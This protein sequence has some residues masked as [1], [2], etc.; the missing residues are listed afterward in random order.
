MS[1]LN[2]IVTKSLAVIVGVI[3]IYFLIN[4]TAKKIRNNERK[5]DFRQQ[6]Y[7]DGVEATITESKA[8]GLVERLLN[9]LSW[10][11][12][13]YPV[14]GE[15]L[16]LTDADL[17]AVQNAFVLYYGDEYEYN[18]TGLADLINAENMLKTAEVVALIN[19]L[20]KLTK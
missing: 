9:D 5:K 18:Y 19:R 6:N 13:D 4:S 16:S 1:G 17:L 7:V 8:R 11:G 14:Y 20:R 2:G 15:L 12:S 3:V 10:F